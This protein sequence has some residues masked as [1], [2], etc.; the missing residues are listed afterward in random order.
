M[1]EREEQNTEQAKKAL[2]L[3]LG[4]LFKWMKKKFGQKKPI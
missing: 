2:G 1:S 3:L 4:W